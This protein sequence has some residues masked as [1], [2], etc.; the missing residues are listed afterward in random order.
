MQRKDLR[1][2]DTVFVKRAGEVIPAV[3][4]PVLEKR[5]P[6]AVLWTMPSTCPSCGGPVVQPAGEAAVYCDN[7]ACPAQAERRLRH[8]VSRPAADIESIGIKLIQAL[9]GAGLVHD[10]GDLYSLT[11]EQLIGLERIAD[12]SAQTILDNIEASKTR[13]LWRILFRLGIRHVGERLAEALVAAFGSVDRLMA[14]STEELLAVDG[15]G[16]EIAVS[17]RTY[18]SEPRNHELIDKLRAGGVRLTAERAH[19][20]GAPAGL[21]LVATGRLERYNR[22]GIEERIRQLGGVVGD[23]VTKKTSYVIVGVFAGSKADRAVRLRVPTLSEQ[24]FEA[25]VSERSR[26][27]AGGE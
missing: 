1:I 13:P 14:A 25:L 8:Y 17:V 15:V 5:P 11:R 21:T 18:F 16:P 2:G 27:A 19:M 23:S 22:Q 3:V 20:A 24:E 6:E 26:L 12:M 7:A 4:A 9:L 10:P